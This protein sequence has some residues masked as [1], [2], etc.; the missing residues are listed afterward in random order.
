MIRP[1]A[2]VPLATVAIIGCAQQGSVMIDPDGHYVVTHQQYTVLQ[3]A[4]QWIVPA[5]LLILAVAALLH[6]RLTSERSLLIF[7]TAAMLMAIGVVAGQLGQR[8]LWGATIDEIASGHIAPI[9]WLMTAQQLFAA[10]GFVLAGL[11]GVVSLVSG[12]RQ[13]KKSSSGSDVA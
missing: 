5:V 10:G 3:E 12:I 13:L 2:I 6:W 1:I 11:G 7:A 8:P 9:Q 4:V